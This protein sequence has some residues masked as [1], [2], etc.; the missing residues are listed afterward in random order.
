MKKRY[1]GVIGFLVLG[2]FAHAEKFKLETSQGG[3]GLGVDFEYA[4]YIDKRDNILM[5]FE[6]E[7]NRYDTVEEFTMTN[8]EG[9]KG[10]KIDESNMALYLGYT[11]DYNDFNFSIGAGYERFTRDKEQLGYYKS[12]DNHLPYDHFINLKGSQFNIKGDFNY[13]IQD[14]FTIK[15]KTILTPQTKLDIEQNT[16]IFPKNIENGD[17]K[18][19]TTLGFS[20]LIE[21]KIDFKIV[22]GYGIGLGGSYGFV[23][24]DYQLKVKKGDNFEEKTQEYDETRTEYYIQISKDIALTKDKNTLRTYIGYGQEKIKKE[25]FNTVS[26][27]LVKVGIEKCF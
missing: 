4:T 12:E 7:T 25:G 5:E 16:K 19:D 24:Y 18:S 17:L 27:N 13:K 8:R 2:Y 20:Y 26:K 10:T 14:R 9:K 21:G 11:E 22:N 23:P 3:D 6:Y 1:L 15:C